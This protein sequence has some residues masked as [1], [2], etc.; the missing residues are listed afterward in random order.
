MFLRTR[1]NTDLEKFRKD[2]NC[3]STTYNRNDYQAIIA[4]RVI[5]RR[6]RVGSNVQRWCT[7]SAS[8]RW[9]IVRLGPVSI[10][11]SAAREG[12]YSKQRYCSRVTYP[13][14]SEHNQ[15]PRES[16]VHSRYTRSIL[17]TTKNLSPPRKLP[18]YEPSGEALLPTM[19]T[20]AH[21]NRPTFSVIATVLVLLLPVPINIM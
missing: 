6:V 1:L 13:T 18:T 8:S 15:S 10:E 5:D 4:A 12:K 11:V 2:T 3:I 19:S 16:L 7:A 9:K 17:H 20:P 21:P 14:P